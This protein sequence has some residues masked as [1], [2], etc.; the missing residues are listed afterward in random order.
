M[1]FEP[2]APRAQAAG[3]R[4]LADIGGTNAR[5]AWQQAAGEP[6]RAVMSLACADH[7][8]LQ[9]ALHA[10]LDRTGREMPPDCAIAIANPVVADRVAMTNHH[11]GFSIRELE[12]QLGLRR[13]LVLNDFTALAMALPRLGPADC[14]QVGGQAPRA[15]S[16]MALIG[17]GTGLGVSGL[18]PSGHGAWLP[19]QG[20]GGHA[21]LGAT[22]PREAAVL[23]LLRGWHG[24]ASA[25]R[26]V[27]GPGLVDIHRALRQLDG[28]EGPALTA[29]SI[30]EAAVHGADAR[31]SEAVELFC[32]FLG[33]AAGNLAL[34]LGAQGGVYIGGGIVP[35]LGQA[36]LARSPL[37]SRFEA[38]GRFADY[39]AQVPV[40]VIDAG[41]TPAF[42]G[43]A[44]ALDSSLPFPG[45]AG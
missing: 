5:F 6:L 34:T 18:L 35:R 10:Y 45:R 4:L 28:V 33:I 23:A 14:W 41:D 42:I 11:W 30:T 22:T 16:A 9:D 15:G 12:A 27:S 26:A 13:L 39:L 40:F 25:E 2:A 1:M 17:P 37:R 29:A 32:A 21:T 24:H 7:A 43:A 19:I 20:E 38:K 31:S 3:P 44:E 8:T 36:W